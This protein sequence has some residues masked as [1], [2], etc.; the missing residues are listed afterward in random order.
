MKERLLVVLATIALGLVVA[1]SPSAGAIV[2]A[3]GDPTPTPQF[4][5]C[6]GGNHCG[7]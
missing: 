7:G 2:R 1:F 3:E 5:A 4:S 6:Q